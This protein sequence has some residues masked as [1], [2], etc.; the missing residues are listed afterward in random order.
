MMQN[1]KHTSAMKCLVKI[2][3]ALWKICKHSNQPLTISCIAMAQVKKI[4]SRER[5]HGSD[6]RKG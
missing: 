1:T 6:G 4:R 5:E 2:S 3:W